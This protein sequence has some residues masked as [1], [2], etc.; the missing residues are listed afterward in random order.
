MNFMMEFC[1]NAIIKCRL[2]VE[3]QEPKKCFIYRETMHGS[4]TASVMYQNDSK[5]VSCLE[6]AM[7][8]TKIWFETS[9]NYFH[10]NDLIKNNNRFCYVLGP[11]I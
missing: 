7:T 10:S 4:G 1:W 9:G 11:V 5:N 2:V 3:E 6:L 8:I